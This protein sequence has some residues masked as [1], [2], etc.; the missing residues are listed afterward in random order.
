M[1]R[2]GRALEPFDLLWLEVDLYDPG[3]LAHVRRSL[4]M[5]VCSGEN[6]Y[7][8]RGFRP[9]LDAGA[10]DVAS[11]DVIWNGF[12]QAKKI[13]DMAE[14]YEVSCAPHNYYSHLATAIAAQWCAAIPNARILE[15]DV[16]DVPWRDE[17]AGGWSPEL[18][19]GARRRPGRPGVGRDGRR[20][21]AART[22]VAGDVTGGYDAAFFEAKA[23]EVRRSAE[24][25]VPLVLE[26][27]A[28][29][30]V[31][32]L[33][34]GTG[35]WL[36]VFA[37]HGVDDVLGV[38]GDWVPRDRLDIPQRA[39]PRRAP[40]PSRSGSSAAST[41]PS[42]SR[43]PS[44][45]PST[46]PTVRRVAD[47]ASSGR[48]VLG[49][50]RRT[51]AGLHHVNEQWQDYWAAR[52]AGRGYDA[53]DAIRPRMWAMDGIPY[54]YVQNMLVYATPEVIAATP[55]LATA[56]AATTEA[57][58]PL[59]HPRMLDPRRRGPGR[60]ARR[61][62]ATA[63]ELSLRELADALPRALARS[64]RHRLRRP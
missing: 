49:R 3:A 61:A 31:V 23:D 37:E 26:L 8:A 5:P 18:R 53:V 2:V 14:T 30:S 15:L 21:R 60:G 33:G 54:W 34:C 1:I 36:A 16:D 44:T 20:G 50:R 45:S 11:V 63:R 10:L 43:S 35:T 6:L 28:P 48:A 62:G 9:Y 59:V 29:R 56:R 22:S 27:V 25:I 55:A 47:A 51:R 4:P 41:W 46:P 13:A 58:L 12:H 40:R 17:L 64:A 52:F 7:T 39:F 24:A 38:D 19:D 57:M 42:R 32:D